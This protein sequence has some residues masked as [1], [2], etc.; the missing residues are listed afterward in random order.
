MST[1]N[2]PKKI[3]NAT[4]PNFD[5]FNDPGQG[6]AS[7]SQ[8]ND[9]GP[10][11]RRSSPVATGRKEPPTTPQPLSQEHH[12]DEWDASKTPPSRFGSRKGSLYATQGTR[13]AHGVTRNYDR[14]AAYHA[15]L[16]EKGWGDPD[17]RGSASSRDASL[18]KSPKSKSPLNFRKRSDSPGGM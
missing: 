16:A 13:D 3:G 9:T 1:T 8:R 6:S 11:E 10:P 17:R 15:K 5:P 12:G 7:N 2:V 4:F 14:D 18:G